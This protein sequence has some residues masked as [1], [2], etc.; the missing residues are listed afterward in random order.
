[1]KARA[2]EARMFIYPLRRPLHDDESPRLEV[3]ERALRHD[4]RH[5][6]VRVADAIPTVINAAAGRALARSCRS[7]PHHDA[8]LIKRCVGPA[9]T[10]SPPTGSRTRPR[11]PGT[12]LA[13]V[14][15][16]IL[17]DLATESRQMHAG[18][19]DLQRRP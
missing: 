10:A 2:A 15:A 9:A 18:S 19:I 4:L 14:T 8:H 12:R 13:L 17:K 16:L 5:Q 7:K 1:V 6:L 3:L 11:H